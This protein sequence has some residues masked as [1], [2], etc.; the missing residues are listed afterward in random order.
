VFAGH[1]GAGKSSILFRMLYDQFS[2]IGFDPTIEDE[3]RM[4]T[5]IIIRQQLVP[6]RL[7]LFDSIQCI[8]KR[9]F[10]FSHLGF[11]SWGLDD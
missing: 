1:G 2:P 7:V 8:G 9:M 11:F 5:S 3:W 6:T 4:E 10:F